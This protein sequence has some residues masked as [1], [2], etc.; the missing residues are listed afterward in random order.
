MVEFYEASQG[1]SETECSHETDGE[2]I[3]PISEDEEI[4]SVSSSLKHE[5]LNSIQKFRRSKRK[6]KALGE[7]RRKVEEA[8]D[9]KSLFERTTHE[10]SVNE[11]EGKEENFREI[12][13]WGVPLLPSKGDEGTDIVLMK[14][15]KARD[16]KVTE[17]FEM[18]KKTLAWRKEHKVDGI[19]EEELGDDDLAQVV[20]VK[21]TD[22]DGH[23]VC[24]NVYGAFQDKELYKKTF[25]TEES[26]KRF[27]RWRVQV[28]EK[29]IKRLSFVAGG[30]DSL[31]EITDLRNSPGP[32]MKELGPASEAA[33][34]LFQ[35]HYPELIYKNIIINMPFWYYMYHRVLIQRCG[36]R[37]RRKFIFARPYRV[38]ET[39]L[40]YISPENIPVEYGGLKRD[41]NEEFTPEDKVLE[42]T[43]KGGANACIEIPVLEAQVTIVW[44][45]MVVGCEISY[46]EEFVPDD[47]GSYRVLL[48]KEK[49]ITGSSRNSF[50]LHETGKIVISLRNGSYHK[51]SVFC[52]Y[53]LKVTLPMYILHKEQ[54][55]VSFSDQIPA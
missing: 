38:T 48:Q 26:L 42:F 18:L 16:W 4:T 39:L 40:K 28:M 37:T 21:S 14:F 53:K 41:T 52:R 10:D 3:E 46:K 49:K 50:Y 24:F 9:G 43:V 1:E 19:L 2:E 47:E 25:G 36:P 12:R 5:K 13:L 44:D 6:T 45:L 34:T 7:L 15:L 54:M 33:V 22:R 20:F 30:V 29:S 8:I 31:L 55:K 23:P 17:A 35:Q 27:L 51:K 32:S 11:G